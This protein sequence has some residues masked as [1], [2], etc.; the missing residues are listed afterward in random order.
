LRLRERIHFGIALHAAVNLG[1]ALAATMSLVPVA[2]ASAS[3]L[4]SDPSPALE[5]TSA[6]L[7]AERAIVVVSLTAPVGSPAV[8]RFHVTSAVRSDGRDRFDRLALCESGADPTALSPS[9]RYR[10][11]FQFSRPT[12]HAAGGGGDPVDASYAEQKRIAM[13]WAQ[14]V[15]PSSQWPVCW[16]RTS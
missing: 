2:E 1:F 3:P 12:W 4:A 15:E 10:G 7:D 6:T 16:P 13:D 9:G 5:R 11:A 14:V 8:R